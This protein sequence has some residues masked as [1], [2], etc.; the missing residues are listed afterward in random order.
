MSGGVGLSEK[1]HRSLS[2]TESSHIDTLND[3]EIERGNGSSQN[4]WTKVT[5]SRGIN[6]NSYGNPVASRSESGYQQSFSSSVAERSEEI[7]TMGASGNFAKV[8]AYVCV[9]GYC[10]VS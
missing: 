9:L 10:C 3:A 8:K 2:I 6:S 1:F 5:K 4:P 7:I